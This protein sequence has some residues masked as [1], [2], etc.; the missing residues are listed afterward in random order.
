MSRRILITGASIAGTT[1]AWWLGHNGFEQNVSAY[2][3]RP[4]IR[5]LVSTRSGVDIYKSGIF[6]FED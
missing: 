6:A 2:P 5:A 1:A 3:P 4:D